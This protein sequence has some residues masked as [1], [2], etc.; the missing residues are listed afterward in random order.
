M[1]DAAI[2]NQLKMLTDA[3]LLLT[4]QHGTRLS[5]ADMCERLGIHRA[6]LARYRAGGSFPRPDKSG[7]WLLAD[8]VKWEME[9]PA[10][11]Q[12]MQATRCST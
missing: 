11:R 1:T 6:T 9:R 2:T 12:E 4:R 8:V 10:S 5:Q 3:V 7:K